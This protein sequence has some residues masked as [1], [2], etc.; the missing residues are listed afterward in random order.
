[1]TK[2]S[3]ERS[4]WIAAIAVSAAVHLLLAVVIPGISAIPQEPPIMRV[5]LT[6]PEQK[7]VQNAAP[8]PAPAPVKEDSPTPKKAKLDAV[9]PKKTPAA[10]P[11]PKATQETVI[12]TPAAD[13]VRPY[14]EGG[15]GATD[16]T[17]SSQA[18]AETSAG[19][20]SQ[21][22]VLDLEAL[23]IIK[24]VVPDYSMFSRK[25]KEEGTVT[26]IAR[27]SEGRVVSAEIERSSGY[28]RLD[29]SALRA[30]RQWI[31]KN[32]GEIRVRVPVTFRLK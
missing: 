9:Q 12:E 16:E 28:E 4:Y 23:E 27:V 20:S 17:S 22:G 29:E 3:G 21:Q 25:R 18:G 31:F 30:V 26:I 10:K 1:M 13:E 14:P 32:I 5:R 15:A 7:S 6:V 11:V 19:T 24:K 8:V 2:G